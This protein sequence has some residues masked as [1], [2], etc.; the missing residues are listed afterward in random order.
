VTD[1]R[2]AVARTEGAADLALDANDLGSLF[3]GGCTATAL[4]S[5]GRVVELRPG[6]LSVA[7]GLFPTAIAPWC[8]QEF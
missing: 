1:G 8:P 7:D 2:A 6:A 3:L 4:A 5:A